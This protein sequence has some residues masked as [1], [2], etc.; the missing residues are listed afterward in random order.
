MTSQDSAATVPQPVRGNM[1]LT[2]DD[3]R[4]WALICAQV[5]IEK[6]NMPTVADVIRDAVRCYADKL[7]IKLDAA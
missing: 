3:A 6:G 5:T 4:L 7:N 1:H 2:G